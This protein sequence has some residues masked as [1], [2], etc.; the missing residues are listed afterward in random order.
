MVVEYQQGQ[1]RRMGEMNDV[2]RG[3]GGW[4]AGKKS[5]KYLSL[6]ATEASKER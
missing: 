2:G 5:A 4:K 6:V 1:M 3:K